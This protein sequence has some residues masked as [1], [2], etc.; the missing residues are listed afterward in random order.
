MSSTWN[1]GW[2]ITFQSKLGFVLINLFLKNIFRKKIIVLVL[3]PFVL[4]RRNA[5][6]INKSLLAIHCNSQFQRRECSGRLCS[7]RAVCYFVFQWL[8]KMY[9][10]GNVVWLNIVQFYYSFWWQKA[11]AGRAIGWLKVSRCWVSQLNCLVP[12]WT[13]RFIWM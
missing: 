7:F 5:L 8:N 11:L 2:N 6:L 1:I 13:N 3:S 12:F 9:R 4:C 10:W